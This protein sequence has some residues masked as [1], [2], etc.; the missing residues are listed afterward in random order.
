MVDE[1]QDTNALQAEIVRR[2]AVAHRN[3]MVVGDDAQSIYAFRGADFRNIM[4]FPR[5]FPEARVLSLDQNYRSTQGILDLA[6]AIINRAPEK[7]TKNLFTSRGEG[8]RPAL[9]QALNEPEQSFFVAQ[10]ILELR[11]EGVPLS[12]IAVL[13]RS[14]FHSFDLE[15]EL[16][17]RDIPFVKRGGFRFVETAH[18]KDVLAHLRVVANPTDTV[19]WHRILML[20]E[21]VGPKSSRRDLGAGRRRLA[22]GGAGGGAGA[23]AGRGRAEAARRG[24]RRRGDAD[25]AGRPGRAG[26]RV[27]FAGPAA[28]ASRGLPEA[29]ARSRAL[30]DHRAALPQRH[31]RCSP[32]WRSSRRPTASAASSPATARTRAC[33]R[34]R[35]STRRRASS[36]TRCSCC[37][38]PTAASRRSTMLRD[39]ADIEE[40]RRLMYVAVTRAK[41]QLYLTYPVEMYDRGV[42]V[43]LGKPSRFLEDLDEAALEPIRSSTRE[44]KSSDSHAARR[45]SAYSHDARRGFGTSILSTLPPATP[46][47]SALAAFAIG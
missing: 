1:Y 19:S 46:A 9:V 28:G 12:E 22:V 31:R 45:A 24:P 26:A 35:P 47:L 27:L 13:F 30:R 4:D 40:E 11:E 36:G 34:S 17:R 38:P 43:I 32:T 20:L 10:R 16:G 29:R 6:N 5:L 14:S 15:I 7:Y 21:G 39:E 3:V 41:D 42:G 2:L 23:R 18:V 8:Q 33:S 37:G 44:R 25:G